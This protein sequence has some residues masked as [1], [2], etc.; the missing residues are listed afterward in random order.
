MKHY[1]NIGYFKST[2][3]CYKPINSNKLIS[4]IRKVDKNIYKRNGITNDK[5]QNILVQDFKYFV[6]NDDHMVRY[7]QKL[8]NEIKKFISDI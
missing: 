4:R 1:Y 6:D 3:I 5:I 2:F 7:D 8:L